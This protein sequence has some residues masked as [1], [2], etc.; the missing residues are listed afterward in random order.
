MGAVTAYLG[1][2]EQ[3]TI[4]LDDLTLLALL[5]LS[6]L[7][8][9]IFV[10]LLFGYLTI[11]YRMDSSGIRISWGIWSTT[12]EYQE[13]EDVAPALEAFEQLPGGWQP[14]WPG[15]YVG[16]KEADG[17]TIRVVATLPV[18][19][20]VLIILADG[21]CFAISPERPLLFMEELAR[22]YYAAVEAP[23][24]TGDVRRDPLVAAT[25]QFV[26]A[27]WT[28]EFSTEAVA[29]G[30]SASASASQ[31]VRGTSGAFDSSDAPPVSV[32]RA[33][34]SETS[35]VLRP[36]LLRDPVSLVLIA[37]GILATATMSLYILV[38]YQD[39]PPS[40]TLHWNVDGLPGR[41]GEPREIWFLPTIAG[42]VLIA[43]IGLAW[44]I[45]LFDRFAARLMLGST[46]IVHIV[47]WIALLMLLR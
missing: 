25:Q 1:L 36:T 47:T 26:D 2:A 21:R 37:I 8:T 10:Y 45:A 29:T 20:Q 39:I 40:L 6:T 19:R 34:A 46:I 18:R 30:E 15:Y 23:G 44:S 22:W 4:P 5:L 27:G 24:Q 32:Q 14:F 7:A 31:P 33:P 11:G 12:I 13:I 9:L 43:N 35:P 41:V 42:L 28:T 3:I 16:R 38:Q 17:A